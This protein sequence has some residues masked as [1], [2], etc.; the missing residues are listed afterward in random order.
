MTHNVYYSQSLD[1]A[2]NMAITDINTEGAAPQHLPEDLTIPPVEQEASS[3]DMALSPLNPAPEPVSLMRGGTRLENVPASPTKQCTVNDRHIDPRTLTFGVELEFIALF[4]KG[5]FQEHFGVEASETHPAQ[6]T[7]ANLL[8]Q[9]G[10]PVTGNEC[11]EDDIS[12]NSGEEESYTRWQVETEG[13][14][15]L[16][17]AEWQASGLDKATFNERFQADCLELVSRKFSCDEDWTDEI[18]TVLQAL[19]HL[20]N[21]GVKFVTNKTTGFH[22][23]VGTSENYMDLRTLKGVFQVSTCFEHLFDQLYTTL[24]IDAMEFDGQ[25]DNFPVSYF[26]VQ[27]SGLHMNCNV[28][29]WCAAIEK[30]KDAAELCHIFETEIVTTDYLG[31]PATTM[32][33]GHHS[34]LNLDN[35]LKSYGEDDMERDPTFT[36]EFRQHE[37]T[38]DFEEIGRHIELC[39]MLV[40]FCSRRE[41]YQ[42]L[43]LCANAGNP[44]FGVLDLLKAIGVREATIDN[45]R[46]QLS[47]EGQM[48]R[49]AEKVAS[50]SDLDFFRANSGQDPLDAVLAKVAIDK[51]DRSSVEALE[52][53]IQMKMTECY[54]DLYIA[55][56][57]RNIGAFK[58]ELEAE[59]FMVE[60]GP[61]YAG[62]TAPEKDSVA[63][64]RVFGE[65][66][67][68]VLMATKRHRIGMDEPQDME[69]E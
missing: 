63:R 22:V 19:D 44:N 8:S 5:L 39:I 3:E 56:D 2:I 6:L 46:E 65:L 31:H 33:N 10:V 58:E 66:A 38:L 54:G 40:H 69:M 61:D 14:L 53:K 24:R 13:N 36:I 26:H 27:N 62:L 55:P 64:G 52:T 20:R 32:T 11:L 41:D 1:S 7:I 42:L 43:Q 34:T 15:W 37:G 49:F 30:C 50:L 25:H 12:I 47:P 48:E 51:H 28:Y 68:T 9:A 23:H 57:A 18:K 16:A 29:E 21:F 59:R 4:P 17:D 60:Y 45:Y 67:G 35:C